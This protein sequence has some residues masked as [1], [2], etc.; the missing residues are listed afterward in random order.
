MG[1]FSVLLWAYEYGPNPGVCG[2][3]GENGTC[4]Q[5]GC[6]S[7][8]T[9]NPANKGSLAIGFPNGLRAPQPA[10]AVVVVAGCDHNREIG[11]RAGVHHLKTL[12]ASRLAA[13]RAP[14]SAL[15]T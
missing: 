5:S 11:P 10:A 14:R 9:N 4:T 13:A 1:A 3:P 12:Y 2:A 8:T 15:R 6:H 7:G